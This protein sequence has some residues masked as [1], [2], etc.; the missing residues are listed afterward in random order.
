MVLTQLKTKP[1]FRQHVAPCQAATTISLLHCIESMKPWE[2]LELLVCPAAHGF[3]EKLAV[4]CVAVYHICFDNY[5]SYQFKKKNYASYLKYSVCIYGLRKHN[6]HYI[7]RLIHSPF[8][9][10]A[11]TLLIRTLHAYFR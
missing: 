2:D 6:K 1:D 5:A 7:S 4:A 11:D 10:K 9:C 3:K 8:F